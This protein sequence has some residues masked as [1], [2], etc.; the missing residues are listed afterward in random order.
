MIIK[1]FV[2]TAGILLIFFFAKLFFPQA[3]GFLVPTLLLFLPLFILPPAPVPPSLFLDRSWKQLALSLLAF[4]IAVVV[5][6]PPYLFFAHY[7]MLWIFH[8]QG[9][10]P[11]AWKIFTDPLL[12]Q[13]LMVAFPE[14]FFFRGYLQTE[15]NKIFQPKWRLLGTHLGWGWIVTSLIFAFAHSVIELQWWHFSIFFPT[16]IFGFLKERCG[17]ITAPIL[18]HTFCNTFMLW[19]VASY[20]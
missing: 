14:E 16:L 1:P 18:F 11:A 7:W 15:L 20:H 5:I 2:V 4:S 6:F 10:D 8:Y 12:Y 17:S 9:F 13:L 19:F 3:I